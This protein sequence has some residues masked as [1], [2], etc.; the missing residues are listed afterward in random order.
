[1]IKLENKSSVSGEK[2]K[3][4]VVQGI[5]FF[6]AL[7]P[8]LVLF[9]IFSQSKIR[10]SRNKRELLECWEQGQW[11][12]AYIKSKDAL[13]SAPMDAFFLRMNGF[14]AYQTAKTQKSNT[15]T[16]KYIDE[17]I[18]SLR[19][20]LLVKNADRDGKIRYTL[21]KAYY[22]KG[23]DYADLSIKYLEEAKKSGLAAVDL[24]EYLGL[25]YYLAKDFVKSIEVLSA[26]LNPASHDEGADLLLVHIAQSYMGMEDW[27]TA[28]AYL[29][30][31]IEAS[32][33]AGLA[34]EARLQLGK[35]LRHSGDLDGA[36]E[37]LNAVLEAGGE[38]AEAAYELGEIY[39]SMGDMIRA[40]AAWRRSARSDSTFAP[41]R[42]RLNSM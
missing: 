3:K 20:V 14:S 33:D 6:A 35:V 7:V 22:A 17:S 40:R 31:C 12:D 21:G 15:E 27:D 29:I 24:N 39:A 36:V 34:L 9:I 16:L 5:V 10:D 1:M 2:L 4:Q 28:K 25:S 23:P 42:V 26:S 30:R 19:K 38:N 18:W 32:R 8:V 41:A 13:A 37:T 11:M